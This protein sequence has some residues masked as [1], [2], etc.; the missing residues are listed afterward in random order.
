LVDRETFGKTFIVRQ[1]FMPGFFLALMSPPAIKTHSP[2]ESILS[3][4]KSAIVIRCRFS[5]FKFEPDG[6]QSG[7][8]PAFPR[9]ILDNV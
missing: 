1:F 6:Q 7:N 9:R 8:R 4:E 2:W 3:Q 5:V